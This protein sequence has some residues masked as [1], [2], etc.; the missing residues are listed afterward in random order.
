MSRNY[1]SWGSQAYVGKLGTLLAGYEERYL[2]R[3]RHAKRSRPDHFTP[4]VD[5]FAI[6][7]S[8]PE[9]EQHEL[10]FHRVRTI[11]L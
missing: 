8:G 11:H 2:E 7:Y 3:Q 5:G 1:V 10:F 9:S 4:E 6:D